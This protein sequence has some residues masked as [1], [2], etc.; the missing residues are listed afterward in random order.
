MIKELKQNLERKNQ[1]VRYFQEGKLS[2]A[3]FQ[4]FMRIEEGIDKLQRK[5]MSINLLDETSEGKARTDAYI[6]NPCP[7]DFNEVA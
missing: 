6:A 3:E 4:G 5:D 7:T 2:E 1:I